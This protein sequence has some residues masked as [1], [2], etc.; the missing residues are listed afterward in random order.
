MSFNSRLDLNWATLTNFESMNEWEFN[1][2]ITDNTSMYFPSDAQV[3]D[4]VYINSHEGI[5]RYTVTSITKATNQE[6]IINVIWDMP[7]KEPFEPISGYDGLIGRRSEKLGLTSVPSWSINGL[8]EGFI[9]DVKNYELLLME[10]TASID[11]P[12]FTGKPVVP[13]P[14]DNSNDTQIANTEW[15]NKKIENISGGSGS[16]ECKGEFKTFVSDDTIKKYDLLYL[17]NNEKVKVAS[18][19]N[20]DC[21]DTVIGF[22]T[23]DA[24][25]G[26]DVKV[27]ME[28]I[29]TNEAWN[30]EVSGE[31]IFVGESGEV[32]TTPNPQYKFL[33]QIG[34]STN[35]NTINLEIDEAILL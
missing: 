35:S 32:I 12:E 11:S 16:V 25:I 1:C 27:L 19:N 20:I 17:N 10:K 26:E 28:G 22:A 21:S 3:N 4:I 9:N 34:L 30:F 7:G 33:Q 15:V 29:I 31:T 6:F 8:S 18:A 23:N 24:N 2:S 5:K 14:S 13:T